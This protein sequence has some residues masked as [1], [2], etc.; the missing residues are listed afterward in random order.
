MSKNQKYF[1]IIVLVVLTTSMVGIVGYL[2]LSN[3]QPIVMTGEPEIITPSQTKPPIT[4]PTA[5][6]PNQPQ[7]TS[8]ATASMP[9]ETKVVDLAP[10]D[11]SSFGTS[12]SINDGSVDLHLQ[13]DQEITSYE[14]LDSFEKNFLRS[15]FQINFPEKQ[16]QY[17]LSVTPVAWGSSSQ[18]G[19]VTKVN[20]TSY[21][22]G[23]LKG[24]VTAKLDKI[25]Y[26]I[27]SREPGCQIDDMIGI[28]FKD[29]PV[30]IDLQINFDVKIK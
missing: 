8:T 25:Q 1:V 28:C 18:G 13:F 9:I 7:P 10:Q 16:A 27:H 26:E 14:S 22:N 24:I 20:F 11:N 6:V 2:T 5:I 21:E 17:N 19:E 29:I 4:T 12:I 30:N 3:W 23:R 15:G